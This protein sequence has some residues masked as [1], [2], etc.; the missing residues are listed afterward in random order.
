MIV[1]LL[2]VLGAI[3]ITRALYVR[4][5]VRPDIDIESGQQSFFYLIARSLATDLEECK[6][7]KEYRE[8]WSL[9][10]RQGREATYDK[11][12]S[13]FPKEATQFRQ[14]VMILGITVILKV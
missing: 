9:I 12:F 6:N 3:Y 10:E 11:H 2:T 4:S 13:S 7:D 14:R 1:A 5:R 8:V